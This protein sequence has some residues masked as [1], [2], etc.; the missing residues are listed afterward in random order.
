[1]EAHTLSAICWCILHINDLRRI[2]VG[3]VRI[4]IKDKNKICPWSQLIAWSCQL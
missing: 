2:M 4:M 3:I 1:M